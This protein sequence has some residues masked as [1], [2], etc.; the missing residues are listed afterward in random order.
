MSDSGHDPAQ[1]LKNKTQ[2]P[3]TRI[4]NV[5]KVLTNWEVIVVTI[6]ED[7]ITTMHGNKKNSMH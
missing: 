1:Q 2:S 6:S 7:K 5:H 4:I 3:N